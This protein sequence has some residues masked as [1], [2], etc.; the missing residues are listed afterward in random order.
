[1]N[2]SDNPG[3]PVS[4][5][6][7]WRAHWPL[8]LATMV[9]FSTIG[10]QSY[11]FGAFAGSVEHA[12]GWTRAQTMFGVTVAMFLGIFLNMIV[13]LVVDRFG[14]R[15]VA[16]AGVI[17][18]PAAFALLGTASGSQANWWLLW[19]AIA[20]G[21]VLVQA[22][23]WMGPIAARFDKSRGL[24]MA[25]ALSGAP[26]AAMIQ[27]KLGTWLIAEFGW[28]HAFMA[29]GAV[30]IALT[31]P[32]TLLWFRD[33]PARSEAAIAAAPVLPG[34]TFRQG[35]RTR[36]F[37]GLV[38]SFAAFSFYN[39][40]ISTNLMLMLGEKGITAASA[41][42][43]FVVLGMV[44]LF[45]RLSV[46]WLLDRFPGNL[47]GMG[48]QMLPVLASFLLLPAHPSAGMLLIIVGA[49]GLATGAEI[50]VVLYQATRHFGLRAFG[51]LFSGIITFG[52]LFS[53][54][55]PYAAG[56]LH[57]RTGSYNPLLMLVM[58]A[59]T[60]GALAMA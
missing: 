15:R 8:P 59:M 46:G 42:S 55:G 5:K 16:L 7:E 32:G 13:G 2:S 20:V 58:A 48:A 44:G 10:L 38:V 14:S 39:M 25:V 17:V 11:G 6:A 21:V 3:E 57:D 24:A 1:M 22:T 56:W 52:A 26:L 49:F 12:F 37:W 45:A 23:V 30:W 35:I 31:L 50:D 29:L 43:L 41:G 18:L 9:G 34:M 60:V 40:T 19:V 51:A 33:P 53:A 54:I 36:A 28:R 4:A 47:I 27:P